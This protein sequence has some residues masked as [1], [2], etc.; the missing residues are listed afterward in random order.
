M[1][2]ATE[3]TYF[4]H[5]KVTAGPSESNRHEGMTRVAIRRTPDFAYVP[6]GDEWACGGGHVTTNRMAYNRDHDRWAQVCQL[7]ACP[8]PSQY[9]NGRCDSISLST[10]SSAGQTSPPES[11]S[12]DGTE[13]LLELQVLEKGSGGR[14]EWEK[15]GG[16][17]SLLS[18]G[19]DG[20]LALAAGPGYP[21]AEDKPDT[22]GSIRLPAAL[23]D[24][25]A[26]ALTA[27][28]PV[29]EGGEQTGE[30]E[31]TRYQWNW[32]YL[33]EPEGSNERRVGMANMAYFSTDGD[34]SQRLLA[35]WSPSIAFQGITDEYLVSEIDRDGNL[36]GQP[37]RLTGAGWGEDN[38]WETMPDSGCVVF[39]LAWV[40]DAPGNNYPIEQEDRAASDYPTT[41]RLTS[42]CPVGTEQPPLTATPP[43]LGDAERWPAP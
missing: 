23:G 42:L 43:P 37:F 17:T 27:T 32:L 30:Q 36:R 15:T 28:V 41:L 26:L 18:L 39:P 33:P 12:F 24:V 13:T 3:D 16:V 20:W 14:N 9:Q 40:G 21:G 10:V 25:S 31:V 8:V 5:L 1:L 29:Y 19:A 38:R 34:S 22:I 4:A 7:D 11:L 2:N 6:M 35:G